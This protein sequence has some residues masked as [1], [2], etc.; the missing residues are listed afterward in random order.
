MENHKPSKDLFVPVET[1]ETDIEKITRP[2]LSFWQDSF[3]RLR[4][5]VGAMIGLAVL[6]ILTL[7]AIFG[8]YMNQYGQFE[9]DLSRA[10][11]P[12]RLKV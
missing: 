11:M 10:K 3:Q 6:I 9:Q 1:K 2:S 5:N 7:M 12:Q 8:P 4:K